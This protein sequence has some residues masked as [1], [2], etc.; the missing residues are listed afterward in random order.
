MVPY[1]FSKTHREMIRNYRK[2]KNA[3]L[4][5][6]IWNNLYSQQSTQ[7]GCSSTPASASIF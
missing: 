3:A 7:R 1:L 2:N 6:K 4:E 5:S